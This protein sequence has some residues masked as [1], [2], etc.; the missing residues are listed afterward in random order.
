MPEPSAFTQISQGIFG[1][2]NQIR[3]QQRQQDL[4]QQAGLVDTLTKLI[5]DVEPGSRPALLDLLTK[6]MGVRDKGFQSVIGAL[7]M[8]PSTSVREQ[9][10]GIQKDLAG[11]MMGPGQAR[12]IKDK[13]N[14]AGLFTPQTPEQQANQAGAVQAG[15]D[16]QNKIV[17]RNP[18]QE[19]LQLLQNRY[20]AELQKQLYLKD[21][22]HQFNL[23][24]LENKYRLREV[25]GQVRYNQKLFQARDTRAEQL[26]GSGQA[27]TMDEAR[28]LADQQL[29]NKSEADLDLVLAKTPYFQAKTQEAQALA[30]QAQTAVA[31]GGKPSEIQGKIKI[32]EGQQNQLRGLLDKHAKAR[33]RALS[34]IPEIKDSEK[35]LDALAKQFGGPEAGFDPATRSFKGV[36]P[37]FTNPGTRIGKAFDKYQKLLKEEDD[38]RTTMQTNHQSITTQFGSYVNAGPTGWD[39]ITL[40]PE[41]GG[42]APAGAPRIVAPTKPNPP[43]LPG[44][45]TPQGPI[46]SVGKGII[47]FDPMGKN[48]EIGKKVTQRGKTYIV[49]GYDPDG[50]VQ[51]KP[52]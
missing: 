6:T 7:S 29:T 5:P 32:D 34:I 45:G 50:T 36:D 21:A 30:T 37:S 22:Q 33:T 8:M 49:V 3:D 11:R 14:L 24:T 47:R 51:A 20:G 9:L 27:K 44:R 4:A 15:S 46:G 16:L 52:E 18:I 2:M 31:Q 12:D 1:R 39:P 48:Y 10:G 26:F 19:E 25:E 28:R 13:A 40:K 23:D 43:Q 41:V 35:N 38:V 17:F 42:V